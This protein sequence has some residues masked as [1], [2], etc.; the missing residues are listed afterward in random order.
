MGG[1]REKEVAVLAGSAFALCACSS[2][3]VGATTTQTGLTACGSNLQR[4]MDGKSQT[5]AVRR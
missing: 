4:P 2:S 1:W 3:A 5:A